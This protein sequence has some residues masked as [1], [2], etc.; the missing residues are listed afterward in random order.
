MREFIIDVNV[1]IKPDQKEY[2]KYFF[3]DLRKATKIRLVIGGTDYRREIREK[4]A[5]LALIADLQSSGNVRSVADAPIDAHQ[6]VLI[7][8]IVD[9]VGSCPSEC[10]DHHIFALAHVSGCLNIL[11]KETRMATCRDTIRNVVGHDTCPNIRVVRGEVA[12]RATP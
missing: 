1:D 8:R 9:A 10:D 7:Q 4:P 3:D 11:T 12:Y 2:P 5:L 6:R